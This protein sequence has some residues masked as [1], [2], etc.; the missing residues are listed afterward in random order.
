MRA[1]SCVTLFAALAG[2]GCKQTQR[3]PGATAGSASEA[4]ASDR[5][6]AP[7]DSVAVALPPV[8]AAAAAPTGPR[9]ETYTSKEGRFSIDLPS[10][11][12]EQEQGG[13]KIIGAQFGTTTSDDRTATCGV[14]YMNLGDAS[15]GNPKVILDAATARHKQNAKVIEEKDV[16]LG[17]FSGRSIVVENDV[18]RKWLRVY[19][20]DTLIYV[21]TCGG[22][23]DRAASDGPIATKTLDSFALV[24]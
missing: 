3:D 20:V 5:G 14:A 13:M 7:L 16:K 24:K 10:K 21:L 9:W 22:P 15:N 11:P 19:L 17:T 4:I 23:F 18:H 2:A 8:D 6:S 12:Q 1:L